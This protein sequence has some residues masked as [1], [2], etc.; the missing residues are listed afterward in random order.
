MGKVNPSAWSTGEEVGHG[1]GVN[2][3]ESCEHRFW[4]FK[5]SVVVGVFDEEHF[6]T[7]SDVDPVFVRKNTLRHGEPFCYATNLPFDGLGGVINDDDAIGAFVFELI[8][9]LEPYHLRVGVNVRIRI[10]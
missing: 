2:V 1:V 8:E 10:L 6:R 7:V 4:L 3:A 9:T 5:N